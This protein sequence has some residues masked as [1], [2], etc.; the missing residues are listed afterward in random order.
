[1]SSS[2]PAHTSLCLKKSV[3]WFGI[4]FQIISLV[5]LAFAFYF[6]TYDTSADLQN[7]L[8]FP[9]P[10]VLLSRFPWPGIPYTPL[11]PLF[12]PAKILPTPKAAHK[13]SLPQN[14]SCT[15]G[16]KLPV[17]LWF[18]C[19]QHLLSPMGL[20]TYLVISNHFLGISVPS[21]AH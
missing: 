15:P 6:P 4:I 13:P 5:Q 19:A 1:M 21:L 3:P 9:T 16:W 12:L 17:L 11:L 10:I 8:A 18:E 20:S 2:A 14:L 7:K